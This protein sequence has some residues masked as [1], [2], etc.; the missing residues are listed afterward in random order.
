MP[1]Q[2]FEFLTGRSIRIGSDLPELKSSIAFMQCIP[3][4]HAKGKGYEK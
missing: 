2:A 1:Q 3:E 4:T